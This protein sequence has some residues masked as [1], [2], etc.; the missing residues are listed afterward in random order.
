MWFVWLALALM[1]LSVCGLYLRRRLIGAIAVFGAGRRVQVIARYA[2]LWLLFGYPAIVFTMVLASLALGEDRMGPPEHPLV[3]WGLLLPFFLAVLVVAQ[4]VPYLLAIDAVGWVHRK[5]TGAAGQLTRARAIA[6]LAIVAAFAVYTPVKILMERDDLR[7]RHYEVARKAR[8]AGTLPP[9]FRIA[10]VADIQQDDYFDA[11]RAGAVMARLT[12][13]KPDVV[14]SG[15]DWINMGS[16]HIAAA[17]Q[18]A[19][20]VKSRLGTF[21]VR[22]DHEHFAYRDRQKSVNAITSAMSAEGVAMLHNEI[23]RFDHHGKTV[24]VAFLT[25]SY[26]ARTSLGDVD[27]LVAAVADADFS[28]LVTHQLDTAIAE[29]AKDRIDL[30]LAAHTHGGQVN[31]VFGLWHLPLA[32]IETPYVDGRYQLGTTTIIVTSG[33]GYSIVPFRYAAVGSV[34]IIDLAWRQR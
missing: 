27:R 18:T 8:A 6:V 31:P 9:P 30:V 13:A 28:V 23:R 17:A 14:L 34:E 4:S 33:V 20:S 29:L 21:T 22:G 19:G 11:K 7:W 3:T 10:F 12:A 25:Y 32:R 26:P 5:L 24:A 1:L 16:D 15:G 2:V